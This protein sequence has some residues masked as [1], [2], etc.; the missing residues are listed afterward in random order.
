MYLC[1]VSYQ[2]LVSATF[3][4]YGYLLPKQN[5]RLRYSYQLLFYN[6]S[7]SLFQITTLSATPINYYCLLTTP[8]LLRL[9]LTGTPFNYFYQLLLPTPI[10]YSYQLLVT[11]SRC[12]SLLYQLLLTVP[13]NLIN[14]SFQLLFSDTSF[15]E[16]YHV[17]LSATH[18]TYSYQVLLSVTLIYSYLLLVT[19]MNTQKHGIGSNNSMKNNYEK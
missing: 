4:T 13:A 16:R 19:L 18:I 7:I 10:S 12:Y 5:I 17:F 2:P 8:Q 3:I 11:G 14:Q 6:Y 15:R 9:L 1:Q